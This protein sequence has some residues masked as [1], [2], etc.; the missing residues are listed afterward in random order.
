[1]LIPKKIQMVL[2]DKRNFDLIFLEHLAQ[3]Y[4]PK[5]AYEQALEEVR[6]F[7]PHFKHYEDYNSYR[8][9]LYKKSKQEV[10][11]PTMVI[12]AVTKGIED[13]MQKHLKVVKIR[14][15]AYDLTIS[16][17]QRYLPDCKPFKNYQSFRASKSIEHKNK[18]NGHI[19]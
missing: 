14:K 5:T 7:A 15:M 4:Q 12:T 16:E 8:A 1:M 13:L 11:V 9:I 17:I 18:K 19:K 3:T 10:E 6:A 2:N